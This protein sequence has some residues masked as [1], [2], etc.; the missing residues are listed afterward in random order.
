[1]KKDYIR[2]EM[3]LEDC[4]LDN[5]MLVTTSQGGFTGGEGGQDDLG[6]KDRDN[7]GDSS[8]G[9]LW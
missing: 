8:W 7:T 2:P 6:A 1:M 4:I 9:D 5:P 3:H